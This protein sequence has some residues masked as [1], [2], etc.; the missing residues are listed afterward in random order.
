MFAEQHSQVHTQAGIEGLK[1]H[2]I[3]TK[4]TEFSDKGEISSLDPPPRPPS[5][6][7][8]KRPYFLPFPLYLC[9]TGRPHPK[10]RFPGLECLVTHKSSCHGAICQGM[11]ISGLQVLVAIFKSILHIILREG[12]VL[13]NG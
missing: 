3:K 2:F 13:Q 5:A 8:D 1:I 12:S 4:F 10:K 6:R 11:D 9:M 7:F